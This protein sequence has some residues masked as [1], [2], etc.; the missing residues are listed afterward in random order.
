MS[1][2]MNY[3]YKKSFHIVLVRILQIDPQRINHLKNIV[4]LFHNPDAGNSDHSR[5]NLREQIEDA[6]FSVIFS[7]TDSND[8]KKIIPAQTDYVAIGGGDGMIRKVVDQMLDRRIIDG[9][10]TLGIIPLG[11]ANNIARTLGLP[12]ETE[13]AIVS[14]KNGV[15]RPVDVGRVSGLKDRSFFLEGLGCGLVPQLIKNMKEIDKKPDTPEDELELAAQKMLKLARTMESG[16]CTIEVDGHIFKEKMLM[17]EVMN[18]KAV[19]PN[20]PVAPDADPSD[21]LL[22]VVYVTEDDRD[23][24]VAFLEGCVDG[25]EKTLEAHRRSGKKVK[26]VTDLF[27]HVDDKVHE[28]GKDGVSID[29]REGLLEFLV[30]SH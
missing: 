24:L 12:M 14:W 27:L 22:D 8:V 23:A 9:M 10:F 19:G 3:C 17:V 26:L 18:M 21:G 25:K 4:S 2:K 16:L 5:K 20:I 13:E 7:T 29:L 1:L 6:G 11:T 15:K 30:P 28:A